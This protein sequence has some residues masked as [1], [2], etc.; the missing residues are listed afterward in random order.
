MIWERTSRKSRRARQAVSG[1]AFTLALLL[2]PNSVMGQDGSWVRQRVGSLAWLHSVFFIDANHGWVVG[3]RGTLL[4]TSDGGNTWKPRSRPSED[5]LRDIYF[6]DESNG[7]LV[8]ERNVYELKTRDEPRTYLMNT[9]DG[10]ISWQRVNIEGVDIDARITRAVF[11]EGGH[12]WA[13]GEGGAIFKTIDAGASWVR[14]AVPTRNL[15]LGATFIDN[16]RGWVVGAGAT[17]LQTSD[18]GESWH[19]T[20]PAEAGGTRFSATSFIDN[21]LGW[22]VGSGGRIFRTVNGGRTWQAQES[23][24]RTDLFDVRFLDAQEGWAVGA[25]GTVIYTSDGG[26]NWSVQQS[27]T[28]HKLERLFF[29][30]RKRGWAVGFGGTVIAYTRSEAPQLRR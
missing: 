25:E 29:V 6:V 22:A 23:G 16:H 17:I 19:L 18:G 9:V 12:G 30:D 14:L 11:R 1:L 5:V 8:C 21:R 13:F 27:G 2:L 20:R 3:S 24:V 10:G 26:A 28:S 7:W 4:T 15:L